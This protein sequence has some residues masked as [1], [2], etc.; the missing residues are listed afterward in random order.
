MP[1]PPAVTAVGPTLVDPELPGWRVIL[2]T[3][4]TG[5]SYKVYH[6]PSGEYAESKRQALLLASSSPSLRHRWLMHWLMAMPNPIVRG[7]QD[8]MHC[9]SIS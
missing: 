2:R 8:E 4:A 7:W 3:T 5:R 1:P 6:G 9:V